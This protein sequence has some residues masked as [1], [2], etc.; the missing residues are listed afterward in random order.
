MNELH[1]GFININNSTDKTSKLAVVT[2]QNQSESFIIM[3]GA[4][5]NYH[6]IKSGD[7]LAGLNQW[8][9]CLLRFQETLAS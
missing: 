5:R 2:K 1:R 8:Q 4:D 7:Y 6:A 9:E 3:R